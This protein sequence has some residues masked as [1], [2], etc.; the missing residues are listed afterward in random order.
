MD[1]IIR[2]S[3]AM[4]KQM[5]GEMDAIIAQK[6]HEKITYGKYSINEAINDALALW[7]ATEKKKRE[8]KS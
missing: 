6:N 1:E 7:I 3:V 2:R 4:T 8:E 5:A